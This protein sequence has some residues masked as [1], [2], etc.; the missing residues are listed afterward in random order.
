MVWDPLHACRLTSGLAP[1]I[2]LRGAARNV[3]SGF[4]VMGNGFRADH[5]F[6]SG[7]E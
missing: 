1:D 5:A 7:E 6:S 4:A 2:S 3:V